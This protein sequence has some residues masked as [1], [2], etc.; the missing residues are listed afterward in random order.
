MVFYYAGFLVL[1]VYYT[2]LHLHVLVRCACVGNSPSFSLFPTFLSPFPL[3]L[4]PPPSPVVPLLTPSPCPFFFLRP[5]PLPLLP[6]SP[7]IELKV[8]FFFHSS[9]SIKPFFV[10]A[11][12][13]SSC[14][15]VCCWLVGLL[16]IFYFFK[17][18]QRFSGFFYKN[19]FSTLEIFA[20]PLLQDLHKIRS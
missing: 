2:C 9:S 14:G 18:M 17:L 15:L 3:T 6:P 1:L 13:S 20:L 12:F 11:F 8:C 10:V 19:S 4:L 16:V 5:L 7:S